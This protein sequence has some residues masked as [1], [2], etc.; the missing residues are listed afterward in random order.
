MQNIPHIRLYFLRLFSSV[1]ISQPQ[2]LQ[3]ENSKDKVRR[4]C[5]QKYI[6]VYKV[7]KARKQVVIMLPRQEVRWDS[8]SLNCSCGPTIANCWDVCGLFASAKCS[9]G[10]HSGSY[11]FECKV[12]SLPTSSDYDIRIGFAFENVLVLNSREGCIAFD[13]SGIAYSNYS[14]VGQPGI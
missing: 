6:I 9:I 10:L 3:T 13:S 14:N 2:M 4:R 8:Q 5:K 12:M 1:S 7:P 11:M